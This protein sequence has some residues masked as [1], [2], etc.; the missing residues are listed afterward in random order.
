MLTLYL[1]QLIWEGKA[2]FKQFVAGGSEKSI[3]PVNENSFVVLTGVLF[4]PRTANDNIEGFN[5]NWS[6]QQLTIQSQRG[7]NV[8]IFRNPQSMVF[9]S[10]GVSIPQGPAQGINLD[11]YE[12]HNS[13]VTFSFTDA[14]RFASVLSAPTKIDGTAF[15]RPLD[16]GKL[17][18]VGGAQPNTQQAVLFGGGQTIDFSNEKTNVST[19]KGLKYAVTSLEGVT[20]NDSAKPYQ[21]PLAIVSYLEISGAIPDNLK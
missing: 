6:I 17:G 8:L 11:L 2:R 18:L 20:G 14:R 4:F 21:I 15:N 16:Y 12:F 13:N 1:E 3:L 10:K 7:Q 19:F 9:S 5:N